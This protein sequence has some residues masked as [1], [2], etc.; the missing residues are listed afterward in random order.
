MVALTKFFLPFVFKVN[1]KLSFEFLMLWF[2][3]FLVSEGINGQG[4]GKFRLLCL[5]L[6]ALHLPP[7]QLELQPLLN[8]RLPG[9]LHHLLVPLQLLCLP[10]IMAANFSATKVNVSS[11]KAV[12]NA[13]MLENYNLVLWPLLL[14]LLSCSTFCITR[15]LGLSLSS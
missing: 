4:N 8:Q 1:F 2:V 7:E 3:S 12:F 6:L 14:L 15:L 10:L 9:V 13:L 5:F 11:S